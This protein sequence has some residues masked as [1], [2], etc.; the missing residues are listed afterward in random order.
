MAASS[1][2]AAEKTAAIRR[3]MENLRMTVIS[4]LR[5]LA[6]GVLLAAIYVFVTRFAAAFFRRRRVRRFR[7]ESTFLR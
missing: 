7:F 6:L 5:D 4:V 2:P 1:L 3:L